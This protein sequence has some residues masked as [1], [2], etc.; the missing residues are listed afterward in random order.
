MN[1]ILVFLHLQS[2][3]GTKRFQA[4]IY[5]QDIWDAI[6]RTRWIRG[7]KIRFT[8]LC[9]LGVLLVPCPLYGLVKVLN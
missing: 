9:W 3:L 4:R 8:C 6:Y 5:K 2:F 1:D 7:S